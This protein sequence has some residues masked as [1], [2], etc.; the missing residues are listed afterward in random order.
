MTSHGAQGAQG[1][2]WDEARASGV[3]T[4]GWFVRRSALWMGIMVVAL[5]LACTLYAVASQGA[6]DIRGIPKNPAPELKV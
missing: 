1:A 5:V 4:V 3:P 6:S 2:A